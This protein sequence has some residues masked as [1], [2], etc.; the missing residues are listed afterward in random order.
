MKLNKSTRF[1]LA[2]FS[3][4]IYIFLIIYTME[5][6]PN[7]VD[8]IKALIWAGAGIVVAYITGR[9][10]RPARFNKYNDNQED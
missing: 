5:L 8:V 10:F 1:R 9:S 6:H 2:L 3:F 4:L 7:M